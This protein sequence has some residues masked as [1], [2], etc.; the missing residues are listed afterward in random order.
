MKQN[1]LLYNIVKIANTTNT[2]E[3]LEY[4]RQL[5]EQEGKDRMR[6]RAIYRTFK[7][8]QHLMP[9]HVKE[10]RLKLMEDLDNKPS[11]WKFLPKTNSR[12]ANY[13]LEQQFNK[14]EWRVEG[15][16]GTNI[17]RLASKK[18]PWHKYL[19]FNAA[20]KISDHFESDLPKNTGWTGLYGE[21]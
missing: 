2:P 7:R 3:T 19:A 12:A 11:Q 21:F 9:Q 15:I 20:N 1:K 16:A 5:G 6:R 18:M 8:K 4:A 17:K 13:D 14:G 10:Q